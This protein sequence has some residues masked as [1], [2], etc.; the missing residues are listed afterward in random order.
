MTAL[1]YFLQPNALFLATDML[2]KNKQTGKPSGFIQKFKVIKEA[3]VVITGIGSDNLVQRWSDYVED[4]LT[5]T[6]IDKLNQLTP[7]SLF[8]AIEQHMNLMDGATVIYQF[9]YSETKQQYVGYAYNSANNF[10]SEKLDYSIGYYP[11]VDVP[12]MNTEN[13]DISQ[14]FIDIMLE[15]YHQDQIKPFEEQIGIGGEIELLVMF[16]REVNIAFLDYFPNYA[17]DKAYL[18]RQQ[19]N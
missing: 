15:Q 4:V 7:E 2:I 13:D 10:Q 14:F 9:G 8:E 17:E 11:L 1:V 12:A 18:D 3:N 16:E 19:L 5:D 6:N